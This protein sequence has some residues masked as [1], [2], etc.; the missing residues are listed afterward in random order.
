MF[1]ILVQS[2]FDFLLLR[3]KKCPRS[4]CVDKTTATVP[5][6]SDKIFVHSTETIKYV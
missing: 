5:A 4:V 6:V 2:I 1:S 3:E